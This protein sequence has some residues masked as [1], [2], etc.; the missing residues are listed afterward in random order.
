M[1]DDLAS[2]AAETTS[3][4]EADSGAALKAV[5]TPLTLIMT[6]KSKEDSQALVAL[7]GHLQSLPP[8]QNPVWVA[9][10]KLA[11]VHFARFVFLDDNMKLAVITTY[12]GSFED[13][14]NDFIDT[15]GEVFNQLLSHM[16][17]APPL[18]VQSHREEFYEYVKKN[19]LTCIPPFYSAYP[20]LT[21]LDIQALSGS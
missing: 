20:N 19:D 4:P 6:A 21:V 10:D 18:P 9:L 7:V 2:N 14:L 17:D 16:E 15:I 13:Y 11:I 1:T 5:A 8:D 3:T 12:D